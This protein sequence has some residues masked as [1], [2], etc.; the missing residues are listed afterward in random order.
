MTYYTL[1]QHPPHCPGPV[2]QEVEEDVDFQVFYQ[3]TGCVE[4][5]PGLPVSEPGH[6]RLRHESQDSKVFHR[7]DRLQ[8]LPSRSY[9]SLGQEDVYFKEFYRVTG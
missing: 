9:P 6:R 8:T 3:L 2:S 1:F 7:C 5:R 4:N